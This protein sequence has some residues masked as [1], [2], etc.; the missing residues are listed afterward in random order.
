MNTPVKYPLAKL[1][2]EK[3][4]DIPKNKMY[5]RSIPMFEG[6]HVIKFHDGDKH[7]CS[8]I[9]HDWNNTESPVGTTTYYSAP[10]ISEVVMWLYEKHGIW[11]D[12]TP[13]IIEHN[14]SSDTLEWVYKIFILEVYLKRGKVWG[15]TNKGLY[16]SSYY[17][18]SPTE[19]CEA[20]IEYVLNSLI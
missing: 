15:E 14:S 17:Y 4:F 11:I 12:P 10:T 19:A 13:S 7:E 5:C 1:L 18:N 16:V 6:S 9:P 20:A 2:K 8:N 3:G